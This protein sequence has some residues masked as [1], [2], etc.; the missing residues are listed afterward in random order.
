MYIAKNVY[1]KWLIN[2]NIDLK[3]FPWPITVD[4]SIVISINSIRS[5]IDD[6]LWMRCMADWDRKE[7]YTKICLKSNNR[8]AWQS[9]AVRITCINPIEVS[10]NSVGYQHLSAGLFLV[11]VWIGNALHHILKMY[12]VKNGHMKGEIDWLIDGTV[13]LIHFQSSN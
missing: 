11:L 6:C 9:K 1:R 2:W 5:D 12:I 13:G 7:S 4:N 10:E 8:K 3:P